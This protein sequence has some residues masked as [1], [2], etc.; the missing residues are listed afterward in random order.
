MEK[1]AE[2][3]KTRE[4]EVTR[5]WSAELEETKKNLTLEYEV[6]LEKLRSDYILES[7][8]KDQE[9]EELTAMVIIQ[10]R[11]RSSLLRYAA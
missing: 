4:E 11:I 3:I 8:K 6:E 10:F 9:I 2:E 1:L 7:S 5:Q